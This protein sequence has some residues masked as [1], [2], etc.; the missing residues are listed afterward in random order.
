MGWIYKNILRPPLFRLDP[1]RAH[2]I[3][4]KFLKTCSEHPA[5]CKLLKSIFYEK[6]QEPVH[7]FGLEFPNPVGLAAG[8]DKDGVGVPALEA[9]GFGFIEVGTVTPENQPGNPRPRLF[10]Y[11]AEGAL[12][13][14]MGFNNAGARAMAERLSKTASPA[15]RTRPLGVNIGKAVGTSLDNAI[16]DYRV[17][18]D[19]LSPLADFFVVNVSSPN[20]KG[21]RDLQGKEYLG[22]LCRSLQVVSREKAEREGRRP[23]PMLLKIAPDNSLEQVDAI[24]ETL[25]ET[26]FAGIV[27]TNTTLARPKSLESVAEPGGLSGEPLEARSTELIRHI[28]QSTHGKLPIIGVGG[29]HDLDSATAKL[30]AGATLIQVYTGF[31]YKGPSLP[32]ELVRGLARRKNVTLSGDKAG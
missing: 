24:L 2:E 27:A 32:G 31:I 28:H 7:V 29:I 21:L 12:I 18:F 1:E 10:R 17:C 20:T 4:I 5:C 9:M 6:Y 16:E 8:L 30:D 14:R 13:N 26:G 19:M 3:G 25:L 22:A 23:W 15:R 11:P